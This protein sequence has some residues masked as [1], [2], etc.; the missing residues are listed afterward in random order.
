MPSFLSADVWEMEK[1]LWPTDAPLETIKYFRDIWIAYDAE[2]GAV[3]A[4]I[5]QVADHI[6]HIRDVAG[7]DHVGI[8]SDYWGMR[9]G[10]IG[11]EDVTGFPSLFA[12]LIQR[13]WS[14]EDLRKLAGK[15]MLRV[16]RSVESAALE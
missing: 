1:K 15:N 13:G 7:I 12:E 9:D 2:F 8:G 10:P 16:M 3:R 11:L 14:D 5:A 4:T 6:E